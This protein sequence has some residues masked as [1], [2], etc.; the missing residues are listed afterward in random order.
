MS[1]KYFWLKLN[2]DFFKSKE[3]KLLRKVAGGDTFT[4]I[5]LEM[6]LESMQTDGMLYF[7]NICDDIAEEI[8]LLL[9]EDIE[10]V[11]LTLGYLQKKNMI[12]IGS[13]D[14]LKMN[15]IDEMIGSET[16]KAELMRKKRSIKGEM[17][18]MLPSVT[19]ELLPV[20]KCYTEKRR[21]EIDIEKEL[22]K[23][24]EK[25][26]K[27]VRHKNGEFNNVLLTDEQMTKLIT[28]YGKQV[29]DDF[30]KR[31]DEYCQ[32]HGKSY[33]DYYLTIRNW[34]GKENIKPT[35]ETRNYRIL[36]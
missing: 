11:R 13:D 29:T 19:T 23:E 9:D 36:K 3:I 30:I 21:E 24:V 25:Q 1:K 6:L 26:K 28:E 17:V 33:K 32:Q 12:E 4:I 7:E 34:I 20:T 5:Y 15:R 27:P 35:D 2:K 8:S 22:D 10:N 31:V 18:T 14:H 16:D